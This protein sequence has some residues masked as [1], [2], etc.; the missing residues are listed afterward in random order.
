MKL[1]EHKDDR[2][3]GSIM[4]LKQFQFL[5]AQTGEPEKNTESREKNQK[6]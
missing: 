6:A 3:R 5:M 4:K 2:R 1:Y